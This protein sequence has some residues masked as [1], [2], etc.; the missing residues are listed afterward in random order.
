MK[1]LLNEFVLIFLLRCMFVSVMFL[2]K[3]CLLLLD[4]VNV[5]GG[6]GDVWC[7]EWCGVCVCG[8]VGMCEVEVMCM[9]VML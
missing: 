9:G 1:M 3:L 7:V 6:G 4:F 8:V 2:V 5:C